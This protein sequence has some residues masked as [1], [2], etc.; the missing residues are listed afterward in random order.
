MK[1]KRTVKLT[2]FESTP[3]YY[4]NKMLYDIDHLKHGFR[5]TASRQ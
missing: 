2:E 5:I 4:K 1:E 3:Q